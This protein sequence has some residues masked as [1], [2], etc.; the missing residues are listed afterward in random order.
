MN[1]KGHDCHTFHHCTDDYITP[2]GEWHMCPFCGLR[3]MVWEFDRGRFTACCCWTNKYDHFSV[4]AE[5]I[6]SVLKRTGGTTIGYDSDGLRKNWN[7]WC[8]TGELIFEPSQSC[9]D[10]RW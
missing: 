4:R 1:N 5:S 2:Q 8:E 3:P 10:S 6:M 9:D 7:H